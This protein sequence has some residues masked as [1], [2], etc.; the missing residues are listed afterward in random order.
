M[1]GPTCAAPED[2]SMTCDQCVNGIKASI[3]QLVKRK[4]AEQLTWSLSSPRWQSPPWTQSWTRLSTESFAPM[5]VRAV[6]RS[7][8]LS[9]GE[10]FAKRCC[11]QLPNP[12]DWQITE[13]FLNLSYIAHSGKGFPCS[14]ARMWEVTQLSRRWTSFS[15]STPSFLM[16]IDQFSFLHHK[17]QIFRP[18]TAQSQ[19]PALPSYRLTHSSAALKDCFSLFESRFWSQ[20]LLGSFFSGPHSSLGKSTVLTL[21]Q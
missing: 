16:L 4:K 8:I 21:W 18:V 14:P 20:P 7:S 11:Y 12:I 15:I 6:L 17:E 1:C 5:S 9:S 10:S 2:V 3:D 19:G 13:I